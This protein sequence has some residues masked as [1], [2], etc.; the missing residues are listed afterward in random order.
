MSTKARREWRQREPGGPYEVRLVDV[1]RRSY[2]RLD[3]LSVFSW[4]HDACLAADAMVQAYPV[5][6]FVVFDRGSN[7]VL[8]DSRQLARKLGRG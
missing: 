3:G 2:T 4:Y 1:L 8:Y 7:R 5:D 6:D